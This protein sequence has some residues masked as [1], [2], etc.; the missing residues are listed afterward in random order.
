MN[1][2]LEDQQLV[3]Q[4]EQLAFS[5]KRPPEQI[6][7]DAL[8]IYAAQMEKTSGIAF[9]R[10]IAGQGRSGHSDISTRD[11]EILTA[12]VDPIHGWQTGQRDASSA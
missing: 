1:I 4:L 2:K 5:E 8:K 9:L 11:E 6:V 10:S 12:E 3:R 7:A